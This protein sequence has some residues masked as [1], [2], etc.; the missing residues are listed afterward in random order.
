MAN[1]DLLTKKLMTS[2]SEISNDDDTTHIYIDNHE[3]S[4]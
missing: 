4:D 3:L 1:I 2:R